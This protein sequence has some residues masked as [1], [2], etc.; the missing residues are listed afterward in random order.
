MS[1]RK[2][3]KKQLENRQFRHAYA[4]E[5]LNLSIGTQIKTIREK[6]EMSQA[7]LAE[8]VGTKQAGISRIE[9]ANY[10]GWSIAL[11]RRLA[12]AFDLRLKVSFEEFGTLWKEVDDFSRA[13][14][15]RRKFDD[16]P[17]FKESANEEEG[18]PTLLVDLAKSYPGGESKPYI[19]YRREPP[20]PEDNVRSKYRSIRQETGGG[21]YGR[22]RKK[23]RTETGRGSSVGTSGIPSGAALPSYGN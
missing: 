15:E 11:L 4:D 13:S 5:H 7:A 19:I 9:S 14:L 1:L 21:S 12:E 18:I 6:Q 17:E 3:L 23:V 20:I 10:N 2:R 16:D 22:K 8:M